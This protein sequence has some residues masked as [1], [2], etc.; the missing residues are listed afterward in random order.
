MPGGPGVGSQ[1]L[2]GL[3]HAAR[4]PGTAWLVDLPGDGSNRGVSAVPE[5]PFTRWPD[6]LVEAAQALDE[7]VMVGH[8]TGG[9]F[10]LSLPELDHHLAGMVM[11][12]GRTPRGP[13]SIWCCSGS[14]RTT[15][16]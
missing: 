7:V 11:P 2:L 10:M 1:S 9:M 4:V 6:V 3:V 15:S 5:H 16:W 13:N 14:A 8:S 12:A